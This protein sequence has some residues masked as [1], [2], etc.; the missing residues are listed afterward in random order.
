SGRAAQAMRHFADQA[1]G[2]AYVGSGWY[3]TVR[4]VKQDVAR[5]IN[6]PAGEPEIAFVP[7]TSAGLALV[8][9]R[10]DW[11]PGGNVVITYLEIP[12]HRYPWEDL[13]RLGVELIEVEQQADGRIDVDDVLEAITDRTRV[14]SISHVQ[15]ASGF[16]I[17]LRP[18]ADM[19]HRA[20]GY[21]CV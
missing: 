7:N 2:R 15:Y 12:A 8:A 4:T 9:R 19:V 6:A 20:G 11:D 13:K 17:D 5:L 16:R 1:Q 14:V 3:S 21:L 18:I 10:L